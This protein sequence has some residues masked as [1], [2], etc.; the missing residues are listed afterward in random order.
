M[1]GCRALTDEEITQ[2]YNVLNTNRDKC[3]FMI[4]ISCGY[5][6]SEI[7]SLKVKDVF[8]DD[9][10]LNRAYLSKRNTKG[11][12][13]GR[14]NIIGP[15]VQAAIEL[16]V[17]EEKLTENMPLFVSRKGGSIGRKQAWTIL[18]NAFKT[19]GLTGPLGTHAL[20]KTMAKNVYEKSGKDIVA[21]QKS[22]GH[23]NLSSTSNYVSA[24]QDA[25]DAILLSL[26][27]F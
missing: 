3:L 16:L 23:V 11:K 13:E 17:K 15:K 21:T 5:R 27:K 20:R 26:D 4:G 1:K 6:I 22:L 25:V 2:V 14:A 10:A 18:K 24:T 8:K 7:L 19:C 12:V 9:K